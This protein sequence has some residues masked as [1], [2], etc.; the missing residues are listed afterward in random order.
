MASPAHL[1]TTSP[2]HS[3]VTTAEM[4]YERHFDLVWRALRRLGVDEGGLDDACQDVFLVVFRRWEDFRGASS[5]TTWIYGIVLR[6]ASSYRRSRRRAATSTD[7]TAA[8]ALI[9]AAANPFEE[10]S[11]REASRVLSQVLDN[12]EDRVRAVFVLVDLEEIT[13][14]Q[15]ADLLGVSLPTARSRLRTAREHVNATL[16]RVRARDEWRLA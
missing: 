7:E 14:Q 3:E 9:E 4:A 8:L 5:L 15:A 1:A 11:W 2:D 13:I 16:A 6:V 10:T 12:L